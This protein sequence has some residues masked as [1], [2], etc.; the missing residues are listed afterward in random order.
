MAS[1]RSC[2]S[3]SPAVQSHDHVTIKIVV[4]S[5]QRL[6]AEAIS[7][8]LSMD[9]RFEL[10]A[11]SIAPEA[12]LSDV[13]ASEPQVVVIDAGADISYLIRLMFDVQ[14]RLPGVK[15]IALVDDDADDVVIAAIKV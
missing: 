10:Y 5:R 4:I 15:V 9:E 11:A 6:S 14:A 13:L 12:P 7:T 8:S 2:L 1:R 3:P